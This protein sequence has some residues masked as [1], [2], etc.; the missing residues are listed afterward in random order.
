M[1]IKEVKLCRIQTQNCQHAVEDRY[2]SKLGIVPELIINSR[3][4]H[5]ESAALP[6]HQ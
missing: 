1:N 2:I 3:E 4:Q 6:C 5:N